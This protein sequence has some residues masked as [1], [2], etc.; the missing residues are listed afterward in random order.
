MFPTDISLLHEQK[1]LGDLLKVTY[2]AW[3]LFA[4]HFVLLLLLKYV[5]EHLLL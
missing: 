5:S 4:V 3:N 2:K 1:Y